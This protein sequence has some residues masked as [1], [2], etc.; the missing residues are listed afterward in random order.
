M[1]TFIPTLYMHICMNTYKPMQHS[2]LF[3]TLF[4]YGRDHRK[5]SL[6]LH[7]HI[8]HQRGNWAP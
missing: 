7:Q 2:H 6:D 8:H 5:M 3:Y 1:H 4:P